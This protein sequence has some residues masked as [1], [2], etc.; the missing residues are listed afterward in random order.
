MLLTAQGYIL[1]SRM[2]SEYRIGKH[3]ERNNH[4]LLTSARREQGKLSKPSVK[5]AGLL[6]KNINVEAPKH[7]AA[8]LNTQTT[9]LDVRL[10]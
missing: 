2:T 1:N 4:S 9:K 7:T 10:L 8:L 6:A 5:R 3:L